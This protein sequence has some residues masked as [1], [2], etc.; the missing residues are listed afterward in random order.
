MFLHTGFTNFYIFV[1]FIF[2]QTGSGK[3]Y[4]DDGLCELHEREIDRLRSVYQRHREYIESVRSWKKDWEELNHIDVC[5]TVQ[6]LNCS[7]LLI[8]DFTSLLRNYEKHRKHLRIAA[9]SFS[10]TRSV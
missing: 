5:D 7:V 2:I 10:S 9:A 4:F 1:I 6:Y 3:E 8:V